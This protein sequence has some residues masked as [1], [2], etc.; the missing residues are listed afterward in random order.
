MSCHS[1]LFVSEPM[2]GI[3]MLQTLLTMQSECTV[4][5]KEALLVLHFWNPEWNPLLFYA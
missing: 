2:L 5:I 1:S 4:S 3:V